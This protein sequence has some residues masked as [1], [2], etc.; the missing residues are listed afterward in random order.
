MEMFDNAGST[1]PI[2]YTSLNLCIFNCFFT[3]LIFLSKTPAINPVILDNPDKLD[4][5][6]ILG[7]FLPLV[8]STCH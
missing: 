6:K 1:L 2:R 3:S 8:T 4:K 7:V 5:P